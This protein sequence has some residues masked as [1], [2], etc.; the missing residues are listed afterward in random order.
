MVVTDNAKNCAV[1]QNCKE[2]IYNMKECD[3]GYPNHDMSCVKE[4]I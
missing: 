2:F 4:I 3:A 1:Q